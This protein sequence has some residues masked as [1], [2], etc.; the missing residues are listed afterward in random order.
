MTS[1]S[2]TFA[3]WLAYV[4]QL[5]PQ[6]IELGLERVAQVFVRM[7]LP[8]SCPIITVG[9]TNGKGSTCT[10]LEAML[11]AAGYRAGLY[12]SP[13]LHHFNERARINGEPASDEALV[14]HFERVEAVRGDT[15]LT[16]FEF[17]SLAIFGLFA[18]AEL[19]VAILEVGLGGRLDAV[20]ILDAD[21][22][23]VTNVGIDHVDYLGDTREQIGFEKAGIFRRKRIAI[24]GDFDP[25]ASLV[26][27][28][29]AIRADL[30]VIGRDF[31]SEDGGDHWNWSGRSARY[32]ALDYPAL[33]GANQIANA[34]V[35][36]AALEALQDRLPV[37]ESAVRAGL[38]QAVLPGRFQ[39]LPGKPVVI[40]DVAHNPHAA[41][42]LADNLDRT[43][44]Y[45]NT[46]AVFGAMRDKDIDG[47]IEYLRDRIDYWCVTDLPMARAA[48]AVE[49]GDRLRAAG[50]GTEGGGVNHRTVQAFSSPAKALANA[51]SRAGENDRIAVFGSFW[52]VAGAIEAETNRR[53]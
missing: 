46:Y 25:P 5:H 10:M 40:L 47:V 14:R 12:T 8:L 33:P 45:T 3:D 41:A 31:R 34:S 26:E 50:V 48:S 52:T 29:L 28:A 15:Q 17:T 42:V 36:L 16:Y 4:E 39:V 37:G 13:H 35:A 51:L 38:A 23:V 53:P 32:D 27:H 49:L 20:N 19:D 6:S 18:E 9:G 2:R 24:C 21:V 1:P 22:A 30:R 11:K 43:G 7:S 44:K